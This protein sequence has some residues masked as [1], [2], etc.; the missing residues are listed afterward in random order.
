MIESLSL[1]PST[2]AIFLRSTHSLTDHTGNIVS[3]I[4]HF[5]TTSEE[6]DISLKNSPELF[7]ANRIVPAGIIAI[8]GVFVLSDATAPTVFGL[9]SPI[10]I[11]F[12][13]SHVLIISA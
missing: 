11:L 6:V 9:D 13:V 5:L 10:V 8:S 1:P 2:V 12:D 7:L 4:F 3:Y